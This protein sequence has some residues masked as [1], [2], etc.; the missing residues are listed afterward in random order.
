MNSINKNVNQADK[1]KLVPSDPANLKSKQVHAR[2]A[3]D[4]VLSEEEV[5][6]EEN[7]AE[8]NEVDF[9]APHTTENTVDRPVLLAQLDQVVESEESDDKGLLLFEN[10]SP[11]GFGEASSVSTDAAAG[12]A[13]NGIS[14][15][16]VVGALGAVGILASNKSGATGGVNVEGVTITSATGAQNHTLKAGDV[17][18]LTVDMSEVVQVSGTPQLAL[19]I[20]GAVVQANYLG[21]SGTNQLSFTYTI[22]AG[23]TDVNGIAIAANALQLNGGTIQD[24][25]GHDAVLTHAA[26][27]D[28]ANYLVDTTSPEVNQVAITSATGAQNNT[29]NAGDVVTLTVDMTEV[30]QVSGTPQLALTIGGAV[31]QAN[32]L[33]GSGTNQLSFTYTIQA[34]QTDANGIAIAANALQLNGGTIQDAA[35]NDAVLT[36]QAVADNANYLVDTASPAVSQMLI[37]VETGEGDIVHVTVNF[38]EAVSVSGT[39][40]LTVKLG[41]DTVQATY[42][43]QATA[44][45]GSGTSLVFSYLITGGQTY[46]NGIQI[47]ANSLQL[48]G[49]SINDAAGNN[50]VL[51]HPAPISTWLDDGVPSVTHVAITSATGA[52]NSTLNAGDVLTVKVDMSEVVLVSG[53]PQL[54]LNIGGS[55]VQAN[56]ASGSGSKQLSFTYTIQAGQTD[57]NGIAIDANAL[58]FNGGTIQDAAGNHATNTSLMHL[59]VADNSNYKVDTTA[60]SIFTT[61]LTLTGDTFASV[62]SNE[63][64]T[65]Y[66]VRND[67][68]VTSLADITTASDTLWNS[69]PISAVNTGTFLATTGLSDGTYKVYAV[70][71]AGNLAQ[72]LNSVTIVSSAITASPVQLSA[73]AGGTGGF[74]INGQ[75]ASDWSGL[76]VSGAGDVNGDGLADLIISA[77]NADP[78][79][80]ID[81]GKT[82][83]VFGKGTGTAVNLSAVEAGTGG[84]VINGQTAGDWSAYSVSGAGDVNGDGLADVVVGAIFA[85]PGGVSNAGK[86]YVVFGKSTG[87]AV[88]LSAVEAGT[89]G[90]VING[91]AMDDTLGY[92]V[93]GAGDVNGDGLADVIVAS[94]GADPSGLSAAGK[95]YVVFGKSSGTAINLSAVEAGTGGF[96]ISGQS[97]FDTSGYSVSGAGDVNGDGLADLIVGAIDADPGGVSNAGKSYVVFGK[98]SGTFVNLSAVEAGTGGFVI[99]GQAVDDTA[100]FSVSGAGDVNGDGL[101]DLIVGAVDADPGGVNHAGKSYVVFGKS[102]GT[103]INLSAV[104]AGTGGFVI[105]G[106]STFDMSGYSVSGAGDLNGDGLADL[107]VGAIGADPGGLSDAGKSYVVFGKNTGTAINLSDIEN[108]AGGF[109]INGQSAGDS[110]GISVSGAGDVNGDGLAD[111]IV[112][113][114]NASGGAGKSYVIFGSTTGAFNQTAVD[115]LGTTGNDNLSDGG[116]ARTLVGDAGNDNFTATAASVLIGGTGNDSFNIGSEMI[117]ALESS[118]GGGGNLDRLARVDGGTGVD[119]L[120]LTGGDLMLDLTQIANQ[121]AGFGEVGSRLSSI[122]KIDL[123]GSGNNTLKLSVGDVLDLSGVNDIFLSGGISFPGRHQLVVS[124]NAGDEVVIADRTDWGFVG[125][126]LNNLENIGYAV[127]NHN[128]SAATILVDLAVTVL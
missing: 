29:L 38:T 4:D 36:H 69:V 73:I 7:I 100:G 83:V 111:L 10:S 30:V 18:T 9:V 17:V 77:D 97:T 68:I 41:D 34:G 123:T 14:W 58:Q 27:A 125:L 98:S 56:Y 22:Q 24:A 62:E 46:H 5:V 104:E 127:Y 8:T 6:A 50:A 12:A 20:G 39:P 122:E 42:D 115:A 19:T 96:V 53:T 49:G 59:A 124:G 86:S 26:V 102:S 114:S 60:P 93:S 47:A 128:S 92:S 99:N 108:G 2:I 76:S 118:Y 105:S 95:S 70:D 44:N 101:A 120:R 75:A 78:G 3:A 117:G 88:N 28:N 52:Q 37:D 54:A 23:Q 80:R 79:G 63:L 107:I 81:A 116:V 91:Q 67:V 45:S 106:Q 121:G 112:G 33:G 31:V 16:P 61:A 43:A 11:A 15:L 113:A 72:A 65:A 126:Y 25:A 89:G 32:Y 84:F 94:T 21:G 13:S 109:V 1:V 74:V 35:G 110:S 103:A 57:A 90:F 71:A 51:T 64:G 85:D 55:V 66:L 119:T 82:Y 40:Q 87:T 48:N